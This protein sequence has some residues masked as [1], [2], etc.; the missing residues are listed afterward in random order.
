MPRGGIIA[1]KK[2]EEQLAFRSIYG[3]EPHCFFVS[4][5]YQLRVCIASA[6]SKF[7]MK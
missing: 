5:I 1:K 6:L 4:G 3:E 7:G 2:I